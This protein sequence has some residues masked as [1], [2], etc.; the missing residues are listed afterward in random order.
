MPTGMVT[1]S[2]L[3]HST[4]VVVTTKDQRWQML[5]EP[6]LTRCRRPYTM[7][8]SLSIPFPLLC[9]SDSPSFFLSLRSQKLTLSLIQAKTSDAPTLEAVTAKFEEV[10]QGKEGVPGLKDVET[11]IPAKGGWEPVWLTARGRRLKN[12]C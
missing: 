10:Y 11:L 8:R 6:D 1:L 3:G 4:G 2:V 5:P 9:P 7:L 12:C